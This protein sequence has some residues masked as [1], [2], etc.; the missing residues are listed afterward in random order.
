M[1]RKFTAKSVL[2]EFPAS[3]NL[4]EADKDCKRS[5]MKADK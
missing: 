1:I 4:D 3:S 2:K 5:V